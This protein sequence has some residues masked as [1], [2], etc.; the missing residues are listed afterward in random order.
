MHNFG[1]A[2]LF[3]YARNPERSLTVIPP[4]LTYRRNEH[5][6]ENVWQLDAALLPQA[7]PR[8]Q[9]DHACSRC[10]GRTS[11][12]ATQTAVG[13]PLYWH[14]ADANENRS[15]TLRRAAGLLV[16]TGT[17]RTRGILTAWYTRDTRQRVRVARVLA[18]V[19]PGE[20]R[21]TTLRC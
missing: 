11:A 19:L 14:V 1:V 18:A 2:P 17:W 4:L 5:N 20:R 15:W 16:R 3:F 10:S 13:F 8:D 6:G 9:P 12:A 7:R 21:P